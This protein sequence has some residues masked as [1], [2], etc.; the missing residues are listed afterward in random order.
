MRAVASRVSPRLHYYY[1]GFY[2]H[3]CPKM[4]YKA[5][6]APSDLLCPATLT[7]QP[8]AACVRAL[9]ADKYAIL[10]PGVT[11]EAADDA[12]RAALARLAVALPRVVLLHGGT[13]EHNLLSLSALSADSRRAVTG[14]IS[15]LL[16]RTSPSFVERAVLLFR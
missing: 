4:R 7:W 11:R 1:M 6:Y 14:I 16:S 15:D 5:E 12:A 9:D 2:V 10:A 3:T 8:L 13:R